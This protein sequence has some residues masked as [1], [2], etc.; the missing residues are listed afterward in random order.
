MLKTAAS[1]ED[2]FDQVVKLSLTSDPDFMKQFYHPSQIIEEG[3]WG[4]R[5]QTFFNRFYGEAIEIAKGQTYVLQADERPCSM[6]VWSGKGTM[7]GNIVEAETANV[8]GLTNMR[9]REMIICPNTQVDIVASDEEDLLLLSVYPFKP[10]VEKRKGIVCAGLTC[11]DY[12][13]KKCGELK[14]STDH[15]TAES[16]ERRCGGSVY[17]TAKAIVQLKPNVR[18]E[19][20]TLIGIDTDGD[21]LLKTLNDLGVGTKYLARTDV[22]PT[23]VAF[24]PVYNDG[25]RACIVIP[26]ASSILNKES[27]LG[28]VGLGCK[29][30]D[31]VREVLWFHLGY[32]FELVHMQ[33]D[34]LAETLLELRHKSVDVAISMDL[35]GAGSS[36]LDNPWSLIEGALQHV[37][38]VHMNWDEACAF[39]ENVNTDIETATTEQLSALAQPFLDSG[40]ALVTITLGRHGAFIQIHEDVQHVMKQFGVAAPREEQVKKWI[41][42]KSVRKSLPS[43]SELSG[44]DTVG[45][46]DSFTAGLLVALEGI[47]EGTKSLTDILTFAQMSAVSCIN[48]NDTRDA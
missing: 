23:Q 1:E 9:R 19:A 20:L 46:G 31:M 32:P 30:I 26:G 27:L 39:S 47:N 21:F 28:E 8:V 10:A 42:E 44:S 11:V 25:E 37:C 13:I 22:Q 12:V 5:R 33:G 24:L 48:N 4:K 3:D 40:V 17:N 45:A 2:L 18:V 16:Y 14:T 43:G 7:N 36:S 29:R 38:H 6:V 15:V 41:A 34:A 35:N